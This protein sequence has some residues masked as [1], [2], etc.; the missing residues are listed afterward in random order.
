VTLPPCLSFRGLLKL[1][2]SAFFCAV[3]L[4]PVCAWASQ[5]PM[6][7]TIEKATRSGSS[8]VYRL[9]VDATGAPVLAVLPDE[10]PEVDLVINGLT[11]A[12]A[13]RDGGAGIDAFGHAVSAFEVPGLTPGDRAFIRVRGSG[14]APEIVADVN[15]TRSAFHSGLGSGIF[16]GI[17]LAIVIFHIVAVFTVKDPA[18]IWYVGWILAVG[19]IELCRDALLPMSR[20]STAGLLLSAGIAAQIG[21]TGFVAAYLRLRRE[22]T[23]LFWIL[24]AASGA[25]AAMPLVVAAAT[26]AR[27]STDVIFAAN[28]IAMSF[29]IGIALI[30]SRAG[31]KPATILAVGLGGTLF[32]FAGRVLRDMFGIASPF[33]DHWSVEY[34]AAFDYLLFSL[35]IAYRARFTHR[36][37]EVIEAELREAAAAAGQDPLTGLLNRRGLEAWMDEARTFAGTIL[38]IDIDGFK[39]I[40]DEGGHAAGDDTLTV[41][42]RIIRHSIRTGDA[43][44]RFGGDEF[45]VLL[46]GKPNA[47]IVS[48]IA[49]RI[50]S[51]IG[52]LLPLG[53]TS[54]TRIGASIGSATLDERTLFHQALERADADAY[55]VKAEHHARLRQTRRPRQTVLAPEVSIQ[56]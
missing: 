27:P 29:A 7:V 42:A 26:H 54:E 39:A 16:Y 33:L 9:Q 56:G 14:A 20:N 37:R 51:A 50:T 38:F 2:G 46:D 41:V 36:E 23:R 12:Q 35:G 11:V 4:V 43:V 52:F 10:A 24:M 25:T 17:L 5:A 22:D 19:V 34:G 32:I 44:A 21:Y 15:H 8:L 18:L 6:R 31:F 53:S 1:Y 28:A 30:R 49:A 55:R 45:V 47:P 40:N 48:D 13:G 3:I